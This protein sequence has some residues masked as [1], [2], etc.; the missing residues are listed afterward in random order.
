MTVS[1]KTLRF[2][3]EIET[4]GLSREALARAIHTVLGGNFAPEYANDAWL[5]T[6]GRGRAW[7]VVRD[8]S[9]SGSYNGEIVSPILS[10]D[11]IEQ[12][13]DI[14]RAVRAAGAKTDHST[15]IHIHVDGSTFNAKSI[16]NLVK[17]VFKQE[18]LLEHVLGITPNRLGRY[19]RP[20]EAAFLR[21]LEANPP[22]TMREVQAAW[23]GS[24]HARPERYHQSRYH[25]LNLNSLFFRGSIEF[26]YFNGTL[27][28]GEVKAYLQL[29]LAL[30][31]NALS[32]KAAS[33]K[34]REFDPATAKYDFRVVLLRLS[35]IGDEFKTARH[36]LTK[37]LA[38]SAAWKRGRR[39]QR[40]ITSSHATGDDAE[41]LQ[42][43][44]GA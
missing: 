1:M 24:H 30:A 38:G 42:A 39:D 7:R 25:G 9:L 17:F 10:Y 16:T 35:L 44:A 3:I 14:L 21:R 43:V 22:T 28:A 23:Y 8:G 13:Q 19:C 4:V 27:H 33:S 31:A 29:V 37:R 32:S 6:D 5:V 12:L 15:G 41:D 26:R 34:R 36:H 40:P 18:R 2:G 20:I 11:D